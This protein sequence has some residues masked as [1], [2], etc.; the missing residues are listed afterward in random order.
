VVILTD[1]LGTVGLYCMACLCRL[2]SEP[3]EW[4]KNKVDARR[5]GK[6]DALRSSSR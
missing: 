3:V 1:D 6:E 2:H 5:C 4:C